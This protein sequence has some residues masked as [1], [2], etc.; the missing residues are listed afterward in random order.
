MVRM[1]AVLDMAVPGSLSGDDASGPGRGDAARGRDGDPRN[2]A[3]PP[4]AGSAGRSG[5]GQLRAPSTAATRTVTAAF[6]ASAT[7]DAARRKA[8][9]NM[10]TILADAAPRVEPFS[11]RRKAEVT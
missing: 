9:R 11:A 8:Y 5:E 2:L 7:A 1:Y 3:D 6:G 10:G 4:P